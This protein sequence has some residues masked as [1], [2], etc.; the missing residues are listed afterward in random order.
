MARKNENT[1]GRLGPLLDRAVTIPS[2]RI[3][4]HVDA[5]RRKNPDA[6]PA[7]IVEALETRFLRR[8]A[9]GGG[10]IGMIAAIP[11]VGT[12]TALVLTGTQVASF[13]RDAAIHVM[14]VADVYGVPIDDI[15]RRRSLLLASLMGEEGANAVQTQLG[16]GSLYW[17]RALLTR[18]PIGTVK[19][20]N[21]SLRR[22]A[23][24]KGA[25]VGSRAL[26]GRLFPFGIGAVIGYTGG[27]S[28]GK[29]VT[30]GVR[31]AFGPAPRTFGRAVGQ[32]PRMARV[33]IQDEA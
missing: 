10:L 31:E 2:S 23:A 26:V 32:V 14:A 25:E 22:R 30:K 6:A 4:H 21:M 28:M 11:G 15:E 29:E 13:L 7:V 17:G 19:A 27:K 12:G 3:H 20:V 18:L 1:G 9:R 16:V 8:A 33:V 5:V 24:R